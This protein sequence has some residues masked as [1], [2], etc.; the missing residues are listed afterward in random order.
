MEAAVEDLSVEAPAEGADLFEFSENVAITALNFLCVL[1]VRADKGTQDIGEQR[2]KE[3]IAD[4]IGAV[5]GALEEVSRHLPQDEYTQREYAQRFLEASREGEGGRAQPSERTER[6]LQG[7]MAL[8]FDATATTST[9]PEDGCDGDES[10]VNS[11]EGQVSPHQM[12]LVGDEFGA[13]QLPYTEQ[14]IVSALGWVRTM[15]SDVQNVLL[16]FDDSDLEE[17]AQMT[18]ISL[19]ILVGYAKSTHR[20]LAQ[21]CRVPYQPR[22]ERAR[23]AVHADPNNASA[24]ANPE[25]A[26]V[27]ELFQ[28]DDDDDEGDDHEGGVLPWD[29]LAPRLLQEARRLAEEGKERPLTAAVVL[30]AALPFSGAAV[31]LGAPVLAGDAALQ[32]GAATP[33]GRTVGHGTKN[34][35]ELGKLG[36]VASKLATKQTL[37]LAS[38]ELDRAGGVTGLACRA[39]EGALWTAR[40]P[41]EAAMATVGMAADAASAAYEQA[42]WVGDLLATV[43]EEVFSRSVE[44]EGGGRRRK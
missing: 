24:E 23:L 15:I 42:V 10:V 17:L 21:L 43:G 36:W 25:A 35:V 33:M 34:A 16:E 26:R 7:H 4:G 31:F 39:G 19:R 20:S 44:P 32:W 8:I 12:R 30:A 28:V 27:S 37:R 22:R 18:L 5:R 13:L 2:M 29:P 38:Q 3:I 11:I 14:D 9:T 6:R 41:V 40:H 1:I